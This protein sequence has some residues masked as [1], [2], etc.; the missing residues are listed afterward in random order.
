MIGGN[1]SMGNAKKYYLDSSPL[2]KIREQCY[3]LV[4]DIA[5]EEY[6]IGRNDITGNALDNLAE[7]IYIDVMALLNNA[8]GPIVKKIG[9]HVLS[10]RKHSFYYKRNPYNLNLLGEKIKIKIW[11]GLP[12][13]VS[14]ENLNIAKEKYPGYHDE[15]LITRVEHDMHRIEAYKLV[16]GF[17]L[18]DIIMKDSVSDKLGSW[19]G[20][21]NR[22]HMRRA[23]KK[24]IEDFRGSNKNGSIIDSIIEVFMTYLVTIVHK[25][26][27]NKMLYYPND[28]NPGNF[29]IDYDSLEKYPYNLQNIDHDHIVITEHKQMI[30]NV[31]WQFFSRLYDT[32]ALPDEV[33]V[34]D[35]RDWRQLNELFDVIEDFKSRFLK[36]VNIEYT[37][38]EAF[39]Y[40]IG[41]ASFNGSQMV[42][43]Y[44]NTIKTA[45]MLNNED[46][47][48]KENDDM[49]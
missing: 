2:I 21:D 35:V 41:K 26:A 47:E 1:V 42:E 16:R 13:R 48:K 34:E 30:N 25:T 5:R 6:N 33:L 24:Q 38:D 31:T 28:C 20:F 44:Y 7:E 29:V 4:Y 23:M 40:P 49:E 17:T 9:D 45:Y 36:E 18:A 27:Y 22:D 43:E 39:D 32:E 8:N 12:S 10:N 37:S 14:R 11:V 3:D 15:N 19:P 46:T